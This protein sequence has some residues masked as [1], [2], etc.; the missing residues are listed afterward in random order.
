MGVKVRARSA[1]AQG[2]LFYNVDLRQR[3]FTCDGQSGC[4]CLAKVYEKM[5]KAIGKRISE[6]EDA[7]LFYVR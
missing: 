3:A 5:E 6:G 7:T 4:N 1:D 2:E